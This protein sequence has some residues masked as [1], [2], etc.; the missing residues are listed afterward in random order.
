MPRAHALINEVMQNN[1]EISLTDPAAAICPVADQFTAGNKAAVIIDGQFGSTGKGLFAAYLALKNRCDIAT[2]NASANAGHTTILEDGTK[3]VTYHLPT[4]AVIRNRLNPRT[5]VAYLNAGAIINPE[6][7]VKELEEVGFDPAMLVIHPRAAVIEPEHIAREYDT[8]SS[9]TK[10]GSTRK[11]VGEA[12]AAKIGRNARLAGDHPLLRHFC[13]KI[14]MND[15]MIRNA[16][17]VVE[18]PQG[19]SLG[20]NSGFSYPHCTSRDVTVAQGLS[21][22]GIHPHFLGKVAMTLRT[23]PIRVGHVIDE[24]GQKIGD[25]GPVYPDQTEI[26]FADI[27][28]ADELTTVTKRVRRVF[29][30][31]IEQFLEA[32]RMN[33][34]DMI[35]LNFANYCKNPDQLYRIQVRMQRVWGNPTHWGVGPNVT[36]VYNDES[37]MLARMNGQ[38]WCGEV[39]PS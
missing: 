9:A 25:S 33:R 30:F 38:G 27:G 34:P 39:K 8:R 15:L 3:F 5:C 37:M 18:I 36:Q 16:A 12:L 22:A 28:V 29:T 7:L 11:G 17:V 35:F 14:D 32:C 24:N 4:F 19:F 26:T 21:D 31:S 1:R 13:D 23:F 2:T 10:L 20:I 6:L